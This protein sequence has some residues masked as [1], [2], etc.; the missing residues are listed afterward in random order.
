MSSMGN[1][2]AKGGEELERMMAELA[3]K[4]WDARRLELL[5]ARWQGVSRG[6]AHADQT[7]GPGAK[8]SSSA[9]AGDGEAS[10]ESTAPHWDGVRYRI[11]PPGPAPSVDINCEERLHLCKAACCKLNFALTPAEVRSGKVKWDKQFPYLIAHSPNGYCAHADE[12]L[13]CTIY[14]DR[15]SLCRRYDCRRDTRIWKDFERMIPNEEWIRENTSNEHRVILRTAI[16]S[17][18]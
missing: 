1:G 12:K 9:E 5:R 17:M 10:G 11:D 3:S 4:G 6:V 7:H 2:P 8:S 14:E 16:P 18:E 15:P 13:R